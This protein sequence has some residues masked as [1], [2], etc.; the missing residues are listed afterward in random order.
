MN[1]KNKLVENIVAPVASSHSAAFI[2]ATVLTADERSNTCTV[3]Y[4]DQEGVLLTQPN[5]PVQLT[6][7]S[8][9]DWFPKKNESVIL[10][11]RKNELK[12]TGPDYQESYSNIKSKIE[13]SNDIYSDTSS[14][15]IGGYIF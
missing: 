1:L 9:I 4:R 14:H 5:V 11:V 6:N 2:R 3:K 8:F 10:S 15:F 12:V 13:L 7:V